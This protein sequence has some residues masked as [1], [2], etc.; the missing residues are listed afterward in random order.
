MPPKPFRSGTVL[1]MVRSNPENALVMTNPARYHNLKM[2]AMRLMMAGDVVR[3]M[4]ALRLLG[5]LSAHRS[6]DMG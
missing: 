5:V 4:K 6:P 2:Q 3:Y 1:G